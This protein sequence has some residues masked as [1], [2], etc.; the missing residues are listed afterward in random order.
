MPTDHRPWGYYEVL[1]DAADH[2][3]KRITVYPGRRLSLQRHRHRSEHWYLI[4][5]QALTTLDDQEI[6]L[7]PGRAV[8]I[9]AGASHRL[10]NRGSENVVFIEVQT[11]DYFGEDDIERIADDFGRV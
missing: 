9:P 7:L 8:D 2:K 3:V 5:G 1:T 4:R 10:A 6:P 11:G